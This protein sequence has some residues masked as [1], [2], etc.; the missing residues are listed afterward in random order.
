[1][2]V[3]ERWRQKRL[4][5]FTRVV[6]TEENRGGDRELLKFKITGIR[7]RDRPVKRWIDGIEED[8]NK[9]VVVRQD[10]GDRE[11]WRRRGGGWTGQT[12][13]LENLPV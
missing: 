10:L 11:G 1:M 2:D 6:R 13:L 5:W 12:P 9:W 4:S 7:K 8:T 3:E